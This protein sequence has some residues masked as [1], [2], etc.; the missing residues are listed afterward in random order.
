MLRRQPPSVPQVAPTRHLDQRL[1]HRVDEIVLEQQ[2]PEA[3]GAP[4]LEVRHLEVER[5]SL[6]LLGPGGARW[7]R[8]K[9]AADKSTHSQFF[10]GNR[11]MDSASRLSAEARARLAI[12]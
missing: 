5:H 11:G 12:P 9:R 3:I 1:P 2:M 7:K 4:E 6:P 10:C 8:A